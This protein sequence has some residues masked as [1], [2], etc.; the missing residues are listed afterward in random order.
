M[1]SSA[2]RENGCLMATQR[3]LAAREEKTTPV[4]QLKM[5]RRGQELR[6]VRP[7]DDAR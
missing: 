7:Q 5:F 1:Q 6:A 4:R 2:W 3:P